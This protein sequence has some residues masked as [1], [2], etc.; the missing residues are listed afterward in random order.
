MNFG[1][2]FTSSWSFLLTKS[3]CMAN[4]VI[5]GWENWFKGFVN[6][7]N[8]Q[9]KK[10]K[11]TVSFWAVKVGERAGAGR[12]HLSKISVSATYNHYYVHCWTV[13][14]SIS[15]TVAGPSGGM[16]NIVHIRREG[17]LWSLN[18][19]GCGSCA[20]VA[21]C[22]SSF[23]HRKESHSADISPDPWIP[24]TCTMKLHFFP[25]ASRVKYFNLAG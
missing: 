14:V 22:L 16:M 10:L 18:L 6:M 21:T 15:S 2:S 24:T 1:P 19:H 20:R 9:S 25:Q 3:C 17:Q 8:K 12:A 7:V 4:E 23:H 13:C 5:G 11:A